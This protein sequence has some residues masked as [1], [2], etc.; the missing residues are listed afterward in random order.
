ME[1]CI[2][3]EDPGNVWKY[4][5]YKQFARKYND[6]VNQIATEIE[7]PPMLD[8]YN[9]DKI[10]GSTQTIA[11]QQK[12]IFESVHANASMLRAY[13]RSISGVNSDELRSVQDFLQARLRSAVFEK[14][15][16]EVEV[17]N[18]LEQLLIGRGLLKGQDYDRETG[19]VKVSAKEVVPDFVFPKLD[20]ALEV[21]LASD[22]TR[23]KEIIDEINADIR[24]YKKKYRN[25]LFIVYD[26]A[27]IRD[28]GEF[29][30]DLEAEEGVS[31]L[32]IKH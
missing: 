21:K 24:A 5:G 30:R 11:L 1:V 2:R 15:A 14:P 10:P 26:I 12:E 23:M 3:S 31:V 4:G 8:C 27:C 32:I 7:L 22:T 13:L 6:L 9:L 16:R 25:A 29:R 28:E 19:R 20:L 17:Q 18:A